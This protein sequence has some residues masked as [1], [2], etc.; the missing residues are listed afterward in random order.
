MREKPWSGTARML[1]ATP[2]RSVRSRQTSRPRLRRRPTCLRMQ[3]ARATR[4]SAQPLTTYTLGSLRKRP[5]SPP[6]SPDAGGR[7]TSPAERG[8]APR[9]YWAKAVP[10]AVAQIQ[11]NLHPPLKRPLIDIGRLRFGGLASYLTNEIPAAFADAKDAALQAEFKTT[12]AAAAKAFSDV[13]AWL[14]SQRKT[15][16]ETFALGADKFS[17]MLRASERVDV[18]LDRLEQLGRDDMARNVAALREAC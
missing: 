4:S 13:D 9:G 14:E 17:E 1:V 2:S 3:T 8:H 12:N 6:E 7:E 15:Q 5:T 11:A 10:G 16:T 18:P